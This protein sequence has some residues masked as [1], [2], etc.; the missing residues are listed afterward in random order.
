MCV[1]IIERKG[2]FGGSVEKPAG[3]RRVEY[4][5]RQYSDEAGNQKC[6]R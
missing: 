1:I 5:K 4:G 6:G 3:M 2:S